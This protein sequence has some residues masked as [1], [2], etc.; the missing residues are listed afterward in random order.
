MAQ[1][2]RTQAL[3]YVTTLV[4][5]RPHLVYFSHTTF[6]LGPIYHVNIF[7]HTVNLAHLGLA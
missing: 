1:A 2:L 3:V 4:F 7:A 5:A 6:S